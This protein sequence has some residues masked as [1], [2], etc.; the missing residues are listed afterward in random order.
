MMCMSAVLGKLP[1]RMGLDLHKILIMIK[2][3]LPATICIAAFQSETWASHFN[4]LNYLV[5]IEALL[6]FCILPRA[7]FLQTLFLNVL[8]TCT[9]VAV[10]LFALWTAIQAREHTTNDQSPE[11]TYN[12][13]AS[14]VCAVWFM[15]QIYF[16]NAL[17]SSRPQFQFPCINY[18][19]VTIISI[20][21]AG[22]SFA[23]MGEARAFM[24]LLLQ[25]FLVGY[26]IA[27][28]VSLFIMPQSNREIAFSSM[29]KYFRELGRVLSAYQKVI[30]QSDRQ[31]STEVA[32]SLN[33]LSENFAAL[34]TVHVRLGTDLEFAV[35]DLGF[36]RLTGQDLVDCYQH[37]RSIYL[38]LLGLLEVFGDLCP[39]ISPQACSCGP[40]CALSI[41]FKQSWAEFSQI[42]ENLICSMADALDAVLVELQGHKPGGTTIDLEKGGEFQ[43]HIAQLARFRHSLAS[44]D[45]FN[46]PKCQGRA[47]ENSDRCATCYRNVEKARTIQHRAQFMLW[48]SSNAISS[49]LAFVQDKNNSQE[50]QKKRII[51]PS[52]SEL[53]HWIRAMFAVPESSNIDQIL[54]SSMDRVSRAALTTA[55]RGQDPQHLPPNTLWQKFGERVRMIPALLRSSHSLFGFRATCASMSIGIIAYLRSSRNFFVEQRCLWAIV[56]TAIAM[57]NTTGQTTYN[58]ILRVLASLAGTVGSYVMWYIV[59]GHPAGAIVFM[60][61][62]MTGS[63][64]FCVVKPKY[65]LLAIVSA[66]TPIISVGYAMN[67]QKLS[68]QALSQTNTPKFPIYQDAAYRLVNVLAGLAVAYFWS[69]FPF[70]VTEGAIMRQ[71]MGACTYLLARYNAIVSESLLIEKRALVPQL[72]AQKLQQAR[73]DVLQQVNRHIVKL[74]ASSAFSKWQ[75]TIGGEFPV[76]AYREAIRLLDRISAE[77]S[78]V[79][80]TASTLSIEASEQ[81]CYLAS[82]DRLRGPSQRVTLALCLLSASITNGVPLPPYFPLGSTEDHPERVFNAAN[83][84]DGVHKINVDLQAL[85]IISTSMGRLH[86]D[87]LL[88]TQTIR[89]I[90]GELNFS[91]L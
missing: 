70:P 91:L 49:F 22:P 21:Q 58:F 48:H 32:Q 38:P 7:K 62:Y 86:E 41:N 25:A 79:G 26:G 56:M 82:L 36:D 69:I 84:E 10:N 24:Y 30:K 8:M 44:V 16:T 23:T 39:G 11:E 27:A 63:F 9:A 78:V 47:Q 42:S 6:A 90:C 15:V 68:T 66:V 57:N 51:F 54:D 3:A 87:M 71:H 31:S 19:I 65:T 40:D 12:S 75:V 73:L 76:K 72:L 80:Y 46:I 17:R 50:W 89:T 74:K 4:V 2:S 67:V 52:W 5:A 61:I 83:N 13:S 20:V 35:R 18:C 34:K 45:A 59:D 29:E 53:T 88:Y 60:F 55:L 33:T 85:S 14:A 37:L 77:L 64:Y 28:G 81:S 1:S 43:F